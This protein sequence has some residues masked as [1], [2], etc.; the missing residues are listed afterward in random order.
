MIYVEGVLSAIELA[1]AWVDTL[2]PAGIAT[3]IEQSFDFLK[4]DLRDIAE[5]HRGMRAIF[6]ATLQRLGPTEQHVFPQQSVFRLGMGNIE[7]TPF[8]AHG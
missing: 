1:A 7:V 4:T 6:D 5:R 3:E 8:F 2:S